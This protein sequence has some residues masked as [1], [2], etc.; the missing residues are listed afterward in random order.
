LH[1][2]HRRGLSNPRKHQSR[3]HLLQCL[4]STLIVYTNCGHCQALKVYTISKKF[5]GLRFCGLGGLCHHAPPPSDNFS[6]FPSA[7]NRINIL[8]QYQPE[9]CPWDSSAADCPPIY[10]R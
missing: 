8:R 3:S 7:D 6:A 5:R 2:P 1:F 9:D 10:C 4:I